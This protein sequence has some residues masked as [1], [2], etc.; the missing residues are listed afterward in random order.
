MRVGIAADH[1]GFMLK[2]ELAALLRAEGHEVTTSAPAAS[3]R[4]TTTPI[5]SSPWRG[6]W[7]K[8]GS[9]GG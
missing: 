9:S 6:P 1:G 8:G 4:R 2:E 3:T 7:R 5:S